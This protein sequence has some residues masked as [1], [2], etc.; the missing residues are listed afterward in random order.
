MS[1]SQI[2]FSSVEPSEMTNAEVRHMC[3]YLYTAK[4]WHQDTL[5]VMVGEDMIEV[6]VDR[7]PEYQAAYKIETGQIK[8]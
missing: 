3:A 7:L 4:Q 2:V 1:N 6:S 5:P 8:L